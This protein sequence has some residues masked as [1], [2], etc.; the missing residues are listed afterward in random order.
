MKRNGRKDSNDLGEQQARKHIAPGTSLGFVLVPSSFRQQLA[1]ALQVLC[2]SEADGGAAALMRKP[3][4]LFSAGQGSISS[5][6]LCC[7][8]HA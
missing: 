4:A 8:G 2:R 1:P 6:F 5:L 3:P 7:S